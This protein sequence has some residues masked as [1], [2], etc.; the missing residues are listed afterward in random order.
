MDKIGDIKN[1][2]EIGRNGSSR[3]IFAK[4]EYCD[5]VKWVSYSK[6]MKKG[7]RCRS[8]SCKFSPAFQANIRKSGKEHRNWHGGR[9]I[10]KGKYKGYVMVYARKDGPFNSMV[11]M[12]PYIPEHRIV[13]AKHLGRC[14][15]KDEHVHHK[16]GIKTDNRIVNLELTTNGQHHKDHHAGYTDGYIKGYEDGKN[17]YIKE[18]ENK[19]KLL[20]GKLDAS[21]R[22][23]E[24]K[25]LAG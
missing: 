3:F 9:Y 17:N 11:G 6:Y 5:N 10:S 8:C 13:M 23:F 20:K 19:I 18:L 24:K 22:K 4:C 2:T 1:A 14:L 15:T 21:E 16:N 12:R 7:R 25:V